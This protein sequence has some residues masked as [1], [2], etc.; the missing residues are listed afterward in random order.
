[1]Q[2]QLVM[3]ELLDINTSSGTSVIQMAIDEFS[4]DKLIKWLIY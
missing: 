1:M 2:A 3:L 4:T